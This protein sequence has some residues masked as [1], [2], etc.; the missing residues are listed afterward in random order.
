MHVNTSW[1]TANEVL[2]QI[3]DYFILCIKLFYVRTKISALIK[4]II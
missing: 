1:L 2:A 3:L 4:T